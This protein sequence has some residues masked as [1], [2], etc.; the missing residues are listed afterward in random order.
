M[1]DLHKMLGLVPGSGSK[2]LDY[3]VKNQAPDCI[4]IR[5]TNLGLNS[6]EF[7]SFIALCH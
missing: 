7:R 3:D 4:L 2:V 5:E 6:E 1:L